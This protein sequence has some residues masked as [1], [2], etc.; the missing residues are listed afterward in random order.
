MAS[1][2]NSADIFAAIQSAA[3]NKA[4]VKQSEKK[5]SAPAEPVKKEVPSKKDVPEVPVREEAPAKAAPKVQSE[6]PT[7]KEDTA[8]VNPSITIP[9]GKKKT[10]KAVAKTFYLD[11]ESLDKLNLW[12]EKYN[13]SAS[14][15]INELIKQVDL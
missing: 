14:R 11:A 12:M 7:K 2:T 5:A 3:E 15:I 10:A 4:G 8:P 6:E 9:M 13:Q 1:K